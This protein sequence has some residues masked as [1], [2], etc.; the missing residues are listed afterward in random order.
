M[1]TD[2]CEITNINTIKEMILDEEKLVTYISISKD[3]CIHVNNSKKLLWSAVQQIREENPRIQLNISY[4]ISGLCANKTAATT[5]CTEKELDELRKTF[6]TIFFY[7]V[8]SVSKGSSGVDHVALLLLNKYEDYSLCSGTIRSKHCIKRTSDELGNLKSHSQEA[9]VL[10]DKPSTV[11][12]KKLKQ[13]PKETESSI[14][15]IKPEQIKAVNLTEIKP[16]T[17]IK[18]GVPS[19]KKDSSIKQ[20]NQKTNGIKPQ[21]GIAS[22]FNKSNGVQNSKITNNTNKKSANAVQNKDIPNEPEDCKVDDEKMDIDNGNCENGI[23]IEKEVITKKPKKEIEIKEEKRSSKNKPVTEEKNKALN[24]IKKTSKVDKKRKR[25]LHVSDSEGDED[26][27]PF[28]DT[29]ETNNINNE[30]DD[31]IPPTPSANIIKITS[32]IVNP[33]KRRKVVDK[34]YTDEDGYI[35]TKKEEVYESCS[36]TEDDVKT[37]KDVKIEKDVKKEKDTKKVECDVSPIKNKKNSPKKSKKKISPPQKG[38]QPTLN[39]FFNRK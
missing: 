20:N 25:V 35:L 8:Y 36:E 14:V 12:N 39:S 18:V 32:G 16:E 7:H 13:E 2:D 37:V 5:L 11:A 6:D 21:K 4:I 23:K 3:L 17:K 10:Q 27:D 24:K 30:S 26:N 28:C 38:K 15:N 9:V 22:F 31:E 29:E 1:D 19:P 34:T 33:K